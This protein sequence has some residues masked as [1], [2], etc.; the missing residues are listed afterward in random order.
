PE[1]LCALLNEQPMGFYPPDALAHEAQRRGVRLAPPDANRSRVLCHV[2]STPEVRGGLVVRVGLGYVKGVREEEM[3]ALVAERDRGGPYRDLA[4]LASRAGAG[5]DGLERLAWAGALDSLQGDVPVDRGPYGHRSTGTSGEGGRRGALWDAG[6][7]ATGRPAAGEGTQMALPLETPPAPGLA[8][9]GAWGEAIADYRMTGMT[10]GE[11]PLALM[12]GEL[13]P[14]PARSDE[15][16]RIDDGAIVE[17][18]GMVVARQRPETA[19]GI[20]F[21]LLEDERGTVNLIVPPPV[22][23]RHRAEVRTS[24]LV[25]AKGRLE[26]REGTINVLVS[27]VTE[28]HRTQMTE[29]APAGHSFGRRGSGSPK[30]PGRVALAIDQD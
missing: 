12:R 19:K 28:L 21:M 25:R 23:E 22:Y 11:H 18:A 13:E 8:P 9:L 2:P 24:P 17:V 4:D 3:R 27:E 7:A 10:L 20:V 5:R 30:R 6:T 16:E 1:F 26:R 15:L 29:V 14:G